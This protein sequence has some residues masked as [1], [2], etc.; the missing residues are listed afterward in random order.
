MP[1]VE[2]KGDTWMVDDDGFIDAFENWNENWVEYTASQEGIE[3][4]NEDHWKLI[5]Y[6]QE[7]YKEYGIAPMIRLLTK[8]TGFKLKYIYELFPSGPAKGACKVAGLPKPTGC[9]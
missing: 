5:N 2:F 8:N 1:K 4:L 3:S 6:L 7:Y 9:V